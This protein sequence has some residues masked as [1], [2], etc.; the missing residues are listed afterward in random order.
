MPEP[1]PD[2]LKSYLGESAIE[3][4]L[5]DMREERDLFVETRTAQLNAKDYSEVEFCKI[6]G[7]KQKGV[8]INE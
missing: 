6:G 7:E 2:R 3:D 1:L 4:E 5:P 8:E